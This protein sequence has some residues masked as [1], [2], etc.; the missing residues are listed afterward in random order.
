MHMHNLHCPNSEGIHNSRPDF[1]HI[2]LHVWVGSFVLACLIP[3]AVLLWPH[4]VV[5]IV[6]ASFYEFDIPF[7]RLATL[8]ERATSCSGICSCV[9]DS[10]NCNSQIICQCG[11]RLEHAAA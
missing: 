3:H 4:T 5:R 6:I 7:Q 11:G 2:W 8:E 9:R 10:P 1:E